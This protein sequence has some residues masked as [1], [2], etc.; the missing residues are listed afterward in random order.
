MK[1]QLETW[2][3]TELSFL[4]RE[5]RVGDGGFQINL[6]NKFPNES[7][8]VFVVSFDLSINDPRFELK[9]KASFVFRCDQPVTEEFKTSDF[10]RVNA[11]AIA[12]PFLRAYISNFTLQSGINPLV[13][14]SIN[15]VELAKG[16]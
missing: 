14:P 3:V 2:K 4:I 12:F 13:L 10:P 11:P 16:E 6:G 8:D 7:I 9:L 1:L 15:F 5:G